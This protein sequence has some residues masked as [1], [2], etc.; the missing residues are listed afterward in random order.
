MKTALQAMERLHALGLG[1]FPQ[2]YTLWFTYYEGQN[3]DLNAAVDSLL[4]ARGTLT[5]EEADAISRQFLQS[6]SNYVDELERV[7][8]DLTSWLYTIVKEVADGGNSITAYNR[9]LVDATDELRQMNEPAVA[10]VVQSLIDATATIQRQ[11]QLLED[12]LQ[13]A[14]SQIVEMRET[15]D[16]VRREV[17]TDQLTSLSNRRYFDHVLA[18][19]MRKSFDEGQDLSL[20][21]GDVDNFKMFNDTWG[22]QTGDQVL[23]LVSSVIRR[24]IKGKDVAA[25]YGGEEFAV[26]LPNTRMQ[27]AST[28]ANNIR[29]E[30]LQKKLIRKSSGATIGRVT[31]S[32]G[33]A[34]LRNGDSP[35]ELI[36]RAD[37]ALYQAK[38]AGRN[39]VRMAADHK[40]KAA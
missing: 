14:Q 8:G 29:N 34:S 30:V 15:M 2:N 23:K 28:L 16:T 21:M 25:R 32:F 3:S 11:N 40:R 24:S 6:G 37:Q 12:R 17:I 19:S 38:G 35:E 7:C 13:E 26:I 10:G 22:H 9:S 31:M 1:A 27:D 33:V 36:E 5:A 4:N 39:C 18:E 20:I